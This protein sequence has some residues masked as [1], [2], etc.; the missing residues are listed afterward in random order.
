MKWTSRLISSWKRCIVALATRNTHYFACWLRGTKTLSDNVGHWLS[1]YAVPILT[2]GKLQACIEQ[3]LLVHWW[4]QACYRW[5]R[6][7]TMGRVTGHMPK[8]CQSE[9]ILY[10]K[11][12]KTNP[13]SL[14]SANVEDN[15][16]SQAFAFGTKELW[17]IRE[18]LDTVYHIMSYHSR[19]IMTMQFYN[20][21]YH[22]MHTYVLY[23]YI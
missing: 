7:G 15:D 3:V 22:I 4:S 17:Y 20:S 9:H 6:G 2:C 8:M 1:C 12:C 11:H 19:Y 16:A 23:I 18:Y 13:K 10:V 14:K 21:W 5:Q